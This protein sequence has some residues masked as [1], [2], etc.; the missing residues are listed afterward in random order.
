[1]LTFSPPVLASHM[2]STNSLGPQSQLSH[3]TPARWLQIHP[4]KRAV[5]QDLH[6]F[7]SQASLKSGQRLH[8]FFHKY[9]LRIWCRNIY[10]V[11]PPAAPS[12]HGRKRLCFQPATLWPTSPALDSFL[13]QNPEAFLLSLLLTS[14]T[15]LPLPY[16]FNTIS[17]FYKEGGMTSSLFFSF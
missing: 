10:D 15:K 16:S 13:E 8:V 1:M 4:Y 11:L 5:P 14:S 6:S 2:N 12:P 9:L 7:P 17:D 3:C